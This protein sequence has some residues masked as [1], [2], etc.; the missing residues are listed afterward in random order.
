MSDKLTS[1]VEVCVC[2]SVCVRACMCVVMGREY[3]VTWLPSMDTTLLLSS[4]SGIDGKP[5]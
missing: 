3:I 4:H 2:V 5:Q 1:T